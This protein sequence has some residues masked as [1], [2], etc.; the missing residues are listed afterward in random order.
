M[1][2]QNIPQELR[3]RDQWM[4]WYMQEGTKVPIGRSNDPDTWLPF[5][6]MRGERIAFVISDDDP[7]VGVDLDD[8]VS[9]GVVAPAAGEILERFSGVAYA[10]F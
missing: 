8:C 2:I 7:Y 9:D 1:E 5:D 3:D 4:H 10:E 6:C